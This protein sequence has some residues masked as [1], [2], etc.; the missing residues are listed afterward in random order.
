M[1]VM[2]S[3]CPRTAYCA[4]TLQP[5]SVI[6]LFT[7]S[8]RSGSLCRVWRPS[9]VRVLIRMYV[10]IMPSSLNGVRPSN[11]G[12]LHAVATLEEGCAVNIKRSSAKQAATGSPTAIYAPDPSASHLHAGQHFQLG[13]L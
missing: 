5:K 8:R 3:H 4:T 12:S 10:G 2:K 7:C 6:S 13:R 11:A 1:T 9:G